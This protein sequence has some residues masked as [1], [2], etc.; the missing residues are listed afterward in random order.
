MRCLWGLGEIRTREGTFS[1]EGETPSHPI[2][3]VRAKAAGK[4]RFK[5]L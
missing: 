5:D 1:R 3:Q 2:G 4:G